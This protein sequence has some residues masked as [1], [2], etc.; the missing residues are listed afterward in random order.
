MEFLSTPRTGREM[1][2]L[3][4]R[5]LCT[6]PLPSQPGETP[7]K[8]NRDLEILID[9]LPAVV[10]RGYIDGTMDF[11]DKKIEEMTG[12]SRKAFASRRKKWT[13]L[14][15]EDDLMVVRK[16]FIKALKTN[17]TYVREYRIRN[18]KRQVIWLQERGTIVCDKRGKVQH[19]IGMMFDITQRKQA[20]E[21][22][23]E[24]QHFLSSIYTS[25]QDGITVLD[26]DFGIVQVNP[27]MSTWYAHAQP[28]IGRKCYEVYHGQEIPCRPCP[29]HRTLVTGEPHYEVVARK[30]SR[31]AC[32]GWMEAYSFPWRNNGNG[33]IRGVI[34]YHRDITERV[35]TADA[36]EA[37]MKKLKKTLN[38]TVSALAT[39]VETRDP[40]TAGHQGR[41][42]QLAC[43]IGEEM[44]VAPDL[45]EGLRIMGFLHDIGKIAV[46]AEILCKPGSLNEFE[47]QIIKTHP[48]MGYEILKEIEFPC[49]VAQAVLQHHERLDGSGYPNGLAEQDIL[50]EA[51]ILAVA[52]VTEAM[53]SHRPYRPALGLEKAFEEISL[54]QGVLYD[55]DVV[56][57]CLSLFKEKDFA[58]R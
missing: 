44:A 45:V 39:T 56:R 48:L 2:S 19:I 9:N 20:E 46:P 42:A 25:I 58:F 3:L 8:S 18:N 11:V 31:G 15:L 51:K 21:A 36:I 50:L 41:V 47:F 43:A 53:A 6:F 40:F 22:I 26:F 49:Q 7:P 37:S 24:G 54:N 35:K 28:L 33:K 29:A 17:K 55:Q 23:Q 4:S 34:V 13:D 10:F 16:A 1:D 14:I 30:N 38:A 52:D 27:T 12:Y 5:D 57:S 32:S